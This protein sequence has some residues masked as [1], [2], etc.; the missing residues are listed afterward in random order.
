MPWPDINNEWSALQESFDICVS[1]GMTDG[2]SFIQLRISFT[3]C[4]CELD[5]HLLYNALFV[6]LIATV[7]YYQIAFTVNKPL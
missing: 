1:T 7:I 5:Y 2:A 6:H 3:D 4:F